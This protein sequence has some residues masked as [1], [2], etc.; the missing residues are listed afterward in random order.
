[1]GS[2]ICQVCKERVLPR[3]RLGSVDSWYFKNV[4]PGAASG[5]SYEPIHHRCD[6]TYNSE[7]K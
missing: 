6:P 4:A 7:K 2:G 1:M 3:F 5:G